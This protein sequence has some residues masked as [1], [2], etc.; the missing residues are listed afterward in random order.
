MNNN[1]AYWIIG[2]IVVIG[3]G[4]ML[5]RGGP[6]QTAVPT[7]D[8]TGTTNTTG[9]TGTNTTGSTVT[10]GSTNAGTGTPGKP[11]VTTTGFASVKT[12]SAIVV[13]TVIPE[14]AETS[15]WFEYGPTPSLGTQVTPVTVPAGYQ[16]LG[17]A[18][19]LSNLK[20]GTQYYFRI[21][22]KNAYGTVFGGPYSL[23]TPAR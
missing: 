18:T 13:G 12:T 21:G 10:S 14:G 8:A 3:L 4:W 16:H 23:I 17:A 15:Y 1:Y 20:P 9:T 22:A 11:V 2:A 19:L 5:M 7:Q 6:S